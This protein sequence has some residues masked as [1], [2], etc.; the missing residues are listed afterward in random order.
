MDVIFKTSSK[1]VKASYPVLLLSAFSI[2]LLLVR[3]KLT[4]SMFFLFLIWNLF[5]AYLPYVFSLAIVHSKTIRQN[6]Y[7]LYAALIAWLLVLPNAPYLITDFV[8][9]YRDTAVPVWFDVLLLTSFTLSGL[10]IWLTSMR[11]IFKVLLHKFSAKSVH[12]LTAVICLLCGFGLYLGRFLRYNSWDVLHRPTALFKDILLSLFTNETYKI[13][14]G[15]TIGFG[16]LQYLLFILYN[17]EKS[18]E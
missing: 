6:N 1:V 10:L 4:Q 7:Y 2:G 8:H 16:I 15:I 14:W 5:L 13:A 12:L 18:K 9:L 17:P 11:H 3:V